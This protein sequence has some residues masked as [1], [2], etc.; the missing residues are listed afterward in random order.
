[1]GQHTLPQHHMK[2]NE[3]NEEKV[4]VKHLETSP[5]IDLSPSVGYWAIVQGNKMWKSN[6]LSAEEA[7]VALD[8]YKRTIPGVKNLKIVFVTK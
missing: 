7:Q 1:M 8:V 5:R 4:S 2:L 3:L 6:L